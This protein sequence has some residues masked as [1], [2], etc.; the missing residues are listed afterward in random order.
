M[1]LGDMGADV[2]KIEHPKRGDPSRYLGPTI[3]KENTEISS[4]YLAL[5]RNKR[6]LG[7]NIKNRGSQDIL[8][9]LLET[10]DIL[11]ENISSKNNEKIRIIL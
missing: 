5:N 7:L 3:K 8:F 4:G 10:A 11:L 2:I 6:S 9:K 1:Y